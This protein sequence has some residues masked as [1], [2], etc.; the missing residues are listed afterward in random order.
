MSRVQ[1]SAL[2]LGGVLASAA[3][4]GEST[5]QPNAPAAGS[6]TGV[7]AGR[8]GDD[9]G[10]AGMSSAVAGEGGAGARAE[11]GGEGGVAGETPASGGSSGRRSHAAHG[12]GGGAGGESAANS[13]GASGDHASGG[14]SGAA[15]S[16]G[17]A[18]GGNTALAGSGGAT[19]GS[20]GSGGVS[21]QLS[22]CLRLSG[23][24]SLDL[25]VTNDYQNA[26]IADCNINWAFYLY[27]DSS[28]G[29]DEQADFLNQLLAFNYELW[30]CADSPPP[31]S[32]DLIYEP[33]PLTLADAGAFI[34]AYV[35][36]AT[37]DL[38]LS[39]PEIADMR[40]A[41]ERLSQPLL[42]APDPGGFSQSRCAA[43]GGAG[44]Q[45]GSGGLGGVGGQT[46][47]G[48]LG[49]AGQAATGGFGGAGSSGT[50]QGGAGPNDTGGGGAG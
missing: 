14:T 30:G 40:A 44:G 24:T 32:F 28:K 20:A 19:A 11:N 2:I 29:L 43:Q 17:G 3:S 41:L 47:T 48:G 45:T 6:D 4:C 49:G 1:A 27:Y 8:S 15:T 39:P 26:F 10:E 31:A 33:E 46:A 5:L 7:A 50:G 35:G 38:G 36:V 25:K 18:Q 23:A 42:V 22:I 9:A 21:N 13:G 12:A 34:D 37:L 16:S